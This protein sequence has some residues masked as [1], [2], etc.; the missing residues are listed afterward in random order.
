MACSVR[1]TGEPLSELTA[2]RAKAGHLICNGVLG[3]TCDT[4][5]DQDPVNYTNMEHQNKTWPART[6]RREGG[7]KY[8]PAQNP[9]PNALPTK[10]DHAHSGEQRRSGDTS[11]EPRR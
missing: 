2:A 9:P 7:K 4:A 11:Q 3:M 5:F 8:P 1:Q 6:E 10:K